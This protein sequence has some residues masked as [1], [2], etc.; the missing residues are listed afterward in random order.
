MEPARERLVAALARARF[1]AGRHAVVADTTGQV[2]DAPSS[3]PGLLAEQLTAPVRWTAVVDR[4]VARGVGL[5]VEVGP[6]GVLAGLVRRC[7]PALRVVACAGPDDHAAVRD[8]VDAADD[9]TT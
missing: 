4:L 6:G 3:W 8:A 9:G 5:V 1:G 7:A 2:P